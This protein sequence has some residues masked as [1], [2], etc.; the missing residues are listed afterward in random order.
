MLRKIITIDEALCNGCGDCV[1]GCSEGAIAIIDGKAKLVK[2]EYCDGFGDCIGNCP[3]GAI[4]IEERESAAFDEYAAKKYLLETKGEGAVKKM[5][6]AMERHSGHEQEI[7]IPVIAQSE[8]R[9]SGCPGKQS[10]F[11]GKDSPEVNVVPSKLQN[12][13]VQLHLLPLKAPYYKNANL[14]LAA[15][16]CA[17]AYGNFHAEFMTN[18]ITAIGCPKLDDMQVYFE[19]MTAIFADN[20]IDS[21]TVAYMEVPCCMGIIKLAEESVKKSGKNIPIKKVKIG[22]RGNILQ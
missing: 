17:F 16:C 8:S 2:D 11:I 3:T 9:H 7:S 6:E 4:V 20:D 21:I 1:T 12:W 22:I 13:P 14:L 19:K 18:R 10:M 15:D 5:E